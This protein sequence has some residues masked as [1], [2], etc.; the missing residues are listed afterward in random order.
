MTERRAAMKTAALRTTSPMLPTNPSGASPHAAPIAAQT[1]NDPRP[2]ARAAAASLVGRILTAK[3]ARRAMTH[4]RNTVAAPAMAASISVRPWVKKVNLAMPT[5]SKASAVSP[6]HGQ[7]GRLWSVVAMGSSKSG[8]PRQLRHRRIA[9]IDVANASTR[10]VLLV[11]QRRAGLVRPRT[12]R[13]PL[14]IV[15]LNGVFGRRPPASPGR[16]R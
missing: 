11:F 6:H 8:R 2:K 5:N 12:S 13:D 15:S 14:A 1:K 10:I 3:V 16:Q 9:Q 4:T 7:F